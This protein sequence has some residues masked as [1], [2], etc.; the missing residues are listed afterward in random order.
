MNFR[1][2]FEKNVSKTKPCAFLQ[3]V[4]GKPPKIAF[5]DLRYR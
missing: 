5:R 4:V 2:I 1:P 3:D